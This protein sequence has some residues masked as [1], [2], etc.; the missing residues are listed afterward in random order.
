MLRVR[1][2]RRRRSSE[3]EQEGNISERGGCTTTRLCQT[4]P[5]Q[6]S[7]SLIYS[8]SKAVFQCLLYHVVDLVAFVA[9]SLAACLFSYTIVTLVDTPF[10]HAISPLNYTYQP[11][12]NATT[13]HPVPS[14]LTRLSSPHRPFFS[15]LSNGVDSNRTATSGTT[16]S[17]SVPPTSTTSPS[18][19]VFSRCL[20]Q[21]CSPFQNAGQVFANATPEPQQSPNTFPSSTLDASNSPLCLVPDSSD[22][23]VAGRIAVRSS[24]DWSNDSGLTREERTQ[25]RRTQRNA[26]D[27]PSMMLLYTTTS[28]I[29]FRWTG[30]G[31]SRFFEGRGGDAAPSPHHQLA[32]IANLFKPSQQT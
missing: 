25:L 20:G 23:A 19:S 7:S 32:H 9:L 8:E 15:A 26:R 22:L 16:I 31:S 10:L 2:G 14:S 27:T 6:I 18:S 24:R 5:Y 12:L 3:T 13:A 28:C 29:M 30:V 1:F 17:R 11:V 21:R 4:Q